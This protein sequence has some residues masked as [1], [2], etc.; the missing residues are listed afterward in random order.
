M[1][2]WYHTGTSTFGV[3]QYDWDSNVVGEQAVLADGAIIFESLGGGSL[4]IGNEN[5]PAD[6]LNGTVTVSHS[7]A[8]SAQI[9]LDSTIS[10]TEAT[11]TV[12]DVS[13]TIAVNSLSFND[14]STTG[15]DHFFGTPSCVRG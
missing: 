2:G 12:N 3:S 13:G 4:I 6:A 8:A 9:T 10:A 15:L 14:A 1:G 5:T 11:Y 7:G